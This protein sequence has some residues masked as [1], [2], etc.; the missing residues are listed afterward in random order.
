M[1]PTKVG[2]GC[3]GLQLTWHREGTWKIK[4]LLGR[5]GAMLVERVSERRLQNKKSATWSLHDP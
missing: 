1:I 5:P 2:I 4:V 3:K